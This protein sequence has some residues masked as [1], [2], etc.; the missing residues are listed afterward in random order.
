MGI[1]GETKEFENTE[2]LQVEVKNRGRKCKYI[3]DDKF[4]DG[5][6]D[7]LKQ[8]VNMQ[9]PNEYRDRL[10]KKPDSQKMVK[11]ESLYNHIEDFVRGKLATEDKTENELVIEANKLFVYMKLCDKGFWNLKSI[12]NREAVLEKV[13][14]EYS[15]KFDIILEAVSDVENIVPYYSINLY[16]TKQYNKKNQLVKIKQNAAMEQKIS[17]ENIQETVQKTDDFQDRE[18]VDE[19]VENSTINDKVN[20]GI[21]INKVQIKESFRI[22]KLKNFVNRVKQFITN[23]FKKQKLL[24]NES[25]QEKNKENNLNQI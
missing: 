5:V 21:V 17:A 25:K 11:F 22:Q 8:A 6:L 16:V 14:S 12:K 10:L 4:V 9:F 13:Y 3:E 1:I 7:N 24:L 23:F 20:N 18:I 19:I 2:E 15:E